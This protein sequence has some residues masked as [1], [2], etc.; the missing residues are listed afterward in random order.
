MMQIIRGALLEEAVTSITTSLLSIIKKKNISEDDADDG[1]PSKPPL[2]L[3][4]TSALLQLQLDVTF[5]AHSFFNRNRCG[6]AVSPSGVALSA[7]SGGGSQNSLAQLEELA[8]DI[9]SHFDRSVVQ[10][11][12]ALRE[13]MREKHL[14]TLRSCDLFLSALFG[15]GETASL[16]MSALA[17]A[18]L[19]GGAT[20]SDEQTLLLNPMPSSRRFVLLPIQ[21]ERSLDELRLRSKYGKE[22]EAAAEAEAAS[23][24][25]SAV[26]SGFGFFSSMLKKK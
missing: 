1:T 3:C 5:I 14:Q 21:A 24:P 13:T 18:A 15:E 26:T 4:S 20:S 6:F 19:S 11:P 8:S 16:S 23:A 10:D 17:G 9:S 2:T 22:K 12:T 7:A 25:S